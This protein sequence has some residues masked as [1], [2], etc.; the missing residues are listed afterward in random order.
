MNLK[1]NPTEKDDIQE[2]W[3]SV[4]QIAN[5]STEQLELYRTQ[6]LVKLDTS[7]RMLVKTLRTVKN[8]LIALLIFV[9]IIALLV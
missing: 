1:K 3:E 7:I 2:Q 6:T 4:M 9:V 8:L 5:A